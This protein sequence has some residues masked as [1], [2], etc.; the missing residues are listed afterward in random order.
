MK[1]HGY[2]L[3]LG[4]LGLLM[5]AAVGGAQVAS[6]EPPAKPLILCI[7]TSQAIYK[8]QL[9][10]D[11]I[12]GAAMA[13]YSS[14]DGRTQIPVSGSITAPDQN[15][16]IIALSEYLDSGSGA[17]P[18]A[19]TLIKVGQDLNTSSFETTSFGG[20]GAPVAAKGPIAVCPTPPAS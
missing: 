8:L 20:S 7:R 1:R 16:I 12:V 14:R 6:P 3:V 19:R 13:G 17:H 9:V 4:V 2:A 11:G 10:T 18:F 5:V 15:T